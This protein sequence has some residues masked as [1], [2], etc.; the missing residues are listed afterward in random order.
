MVGLSL[1]EASGYARAIEPRRLTFP[2]DMGVHP[3]FQTEW[4]YYT[5]NLSAADGRSFGYQL[6]FF[7]RALAP[8]GSQA[9]RES[10][11]AASQVYFAH[12]TLT[13]INS[14]TFNF[15]ERFQRGAAGLAGAAG[16]PRYQVWLDD[17]SVRQTDAGRYTLASR[18]GRASD[19]AGD[20]RPQGAGAAR[21]RRP[22]SKE[23]PARKRLLLREP[24][25]ARQPGHDPSG[26]PE[27][28]GDRP[29][30]DGSRIQH[31]L[32]GE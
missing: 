31:Q 20:D 9:A 25:P 23:R 22:E 30:L 6:T 18:G 16:E 19:L 15:Y 27:L 32:A 3:D 11:W 7:R 13:D 21:D 8:P 14:G 10:E 12:F 2:L 24:D 29:E 28:C 5:G 1:P 17:W 4:W 26:R